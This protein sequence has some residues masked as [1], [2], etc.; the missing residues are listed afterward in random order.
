ML[1]IKYVTQSVSEQFAALGCYDG[2]CK[3]LNSVTWSVLK[4]WKHTADAI[5]KNTVLYN[6]E[7][8]ANG[9]RFEIIDKDQGFQLPF[10]KAHHDD[11]Y[12]LVGVGI[13][14]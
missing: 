14:K 6:E 4:E 9:S 7:S 8:S 3:L 10:L 11:P 1:G 2:T 12:L 13:A 5:T